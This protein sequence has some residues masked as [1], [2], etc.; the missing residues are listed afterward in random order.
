MNEQ[1]ASA[2]KWEVGKA[3]ETRD[4]NLVRVV[5]ISPKAQVVRVEFENGGVEN[6]RGKDGVCEYDHNYDVIGPWVRQAFEWVLWKNYKTRSGHK[7]CLISINDN[8]AGLK[9]NDTDCEAKI[10]VD[11][12]TG[13]DTGCAMSN[14]IIGP[15]DAATPGYAGAHLHD[16]NTPDDRRPRVDLRTDSQAAH[17]RAVLRLRQHRLARWGLAEHVRWESES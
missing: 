14:D 6:I 8:V 7:A 3:H 12:N 15:W 13:K 11:V 5:Y 4:G 1:E 17:D 9:V 10:Y 2:I 16:I